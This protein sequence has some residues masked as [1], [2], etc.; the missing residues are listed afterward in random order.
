MMGKAVSE[1]AGK[2]APELD[3]STPPTELPQVYSQVEG[4]FELGGEE[5]VPVH[6]TDQSSVAAA[7]V[8][9]VRASPTNPAAQGGGEHDN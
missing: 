4:V 2:E 6:S 7:E 8:R 3:A 9:N 1:L 5:I